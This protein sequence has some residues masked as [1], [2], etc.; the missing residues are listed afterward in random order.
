MPWETALQKQPVGGEIDWAGTQPKPRQET[1]GEVPNQDP[2]SVFSTGG[3]K[4]KLESEPNKPCG[5]QLQTLDQG[6][7]SKENSRPDF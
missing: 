5:A 3:S 1:R 7:F 4:R 6:R 2:P